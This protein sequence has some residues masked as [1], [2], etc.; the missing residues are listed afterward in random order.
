[1]L[2]NTIENSNKEILT[3]G[4]TNPFANTIELS[5]PV[6]IPNADVTLTDATGRTVRSWQNIRLDR[7][8][9][10]KLRVENPGSGFYL[11][12]VSGAE[13]NV[14]LKLISVN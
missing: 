8:V 13:Q 9:I 3:W 10:E 7:G 6:N 5:P 11:L 4:C 1:M 12:R 14:C 2:I